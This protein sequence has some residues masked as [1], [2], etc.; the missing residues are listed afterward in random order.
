MINLWSCCWRRHF[1]NAQRWRIY[2]S[3]GTRTNRQPIAWQAQEQFICVV[4]INVAG[5]SVLF[6]Y[7][8]EL[9]EG[10]VFS[11]ESNGMTHTF[12]YVS[13]TQYHLITD[14]LFVYRNF[15]YLCD[16][17]TNFYFSLMRF[18]QVMVMTA[19]VGRQSNSDVDKQSAEE[20]S[21][22]DDYADHVQPIISRDKSTVN[23]TVHISQSSGQ[24][25]VSKQ[26]INTNTDKFDH[27]F[28]YSRNKD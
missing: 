16:Q 21:N 6:K 26:A 9:P 19:G 18:L 8:A 4:S 22:Y 17:K 27:I 24:G 15:W 12:R 11:S 23:N 2:R 5:I 20:L 25:V 10:P 7:I 13:A 14:N 1:A 3:F 28:L